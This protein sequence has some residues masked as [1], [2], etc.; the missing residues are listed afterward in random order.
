RPRDLATY[1][2]Y[3]KGRYLWGRRTPGDLRR[4][5]W[6]FEQAVAR[7]PTYAQAYAGL[8]DARVLLVLLGDGPPVDEVPR[9]RAAAAAAIRLDPALAEAHA[10]LG[11]IREAFDWDSM[12]ADQELAQAVALDPG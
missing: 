4:A 9:A 2:L 1:E 10:A 12:G 5:A 3:L 11:N 6:Y 8:A 7:D